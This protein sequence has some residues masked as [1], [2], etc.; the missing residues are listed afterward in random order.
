METVDVREKA[1]S[2]ALS[3]AVVGDSA[4]KVIADARVFADFLMGKYNPVANELLLK[5]S[6]RTGLWEAGQDGH[7]P[8]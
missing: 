1:I 6:W 3:I 5:Q 2:M 8:S 4:A 7:D